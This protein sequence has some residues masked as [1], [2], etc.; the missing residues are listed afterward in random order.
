MKHLI[1][2]HRHRGDILCIFNL[3]KVKKVSYEYEKDV[4]FMVIKV[5]KEEYK[6]ADYNNYK[7][8]II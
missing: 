8:K 7:L 1:I 5:G 4:C 2:E 6:F 3:K